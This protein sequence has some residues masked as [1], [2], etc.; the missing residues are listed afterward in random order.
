MAGIAAL[1]VS[2]VIGL[3]IGTVLINREKQRA[4]QSFRQARQ[5]VDDY[6][7]TVGDNKLLNVPGLQPLRKD[8]LD[9]ALKYYEGFIRERAGDRSVQAE[10]AATYY[11]VAW[12]SGIVGT[13]DQ[14]RQA[15]LKSLAMYE[16][17]TRYH[18]THIRYQTDLAT[19]CNDLGNLHQEL[20]QRDE[21]LSNPPEGAGD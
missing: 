3:S 8:L 5:A 13:T 4:E 18:P 14:A 19:V 17:L 12:I 15:Y 1:L 21:A 16:V 2:A 6:F 9:R 11:R 20:G 7:T 10:L